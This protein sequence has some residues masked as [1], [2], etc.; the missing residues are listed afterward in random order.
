M[1]FH[2]SFHL[3]LYLIMVNHNVLKFILVKFQFI[4]FN[5]LIFLIKNSLNNLHILL[6]ILLILYLVLYQIMITLY[7]LYHELMKLLV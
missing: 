6:L 2:Q 3:N 4:F 1:V 7:Y 5:H